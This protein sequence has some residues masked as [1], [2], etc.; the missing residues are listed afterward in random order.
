VTISS[1]EIRRNITLLLEGD[2]YQ[3]LEWQHH[4]PP[5]AP[6]TLTLKVRQVKTGNVYSKKVQGN[7]PLTLAATTRQ[8]AQ[9]LYGDGDMHTFMDTDTFEQFPITEAVLG[10]ALNF[11]VEGDN[12]EVL[13]YEGNPIS[14]ELPAA[15]ELTVTEAE[16]GVKGD[17]ATGATKLATANTGL[18]LQVP[19]FVN[20]GD[21]IKVDTRSGQYLERAK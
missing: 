8:I 2:V 11:L 4:K 10:E 20:E 9:Y 18:K 13:V 3:V 1:S 12:I 15:V 16:P 21:V 6:P 7:R 14:V 5:K 17:T 19:L